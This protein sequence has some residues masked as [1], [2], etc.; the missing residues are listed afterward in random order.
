MNQSPKAW[1][2]VQT[3]PRKERLAAEQLERQG[4]ITF[5]PERAETAA[6]PTAR[7]AK[8]TSIFPNYIFVQIDR[9][10]QTWGPINSTIGVSR[11]VMA[12]TRPAVLR[13]GFIEEL[14]HY[15]QDPQSSSLWPPEELPPGTKVKVIQGAFDGMVGLVQRSSGAENIRLLMTLLGG[16]VS[17]TVDRTKVAIVQHTG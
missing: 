3:K 15:L 10:L 9:N 13:P 7:S 5:L 16:E 2:A 17:V 14:Q 1:A 8:P 12:G 11:L 6:R 4:F